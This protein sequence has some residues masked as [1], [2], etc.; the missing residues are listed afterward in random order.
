MDDLLISQKLYEHV[1]DPQ[2]FNKYLNNMYSNSISSQTVSSSGL[3]R[4]HSSSSLFGGFRS[5]SSM[6]LSNLTGSSANL[7]ALS[8]PNNNNNNNN[9]QNSTNKPNSNGYV[10]VQGN[11]EIPFSSILPGNLPESIEGLPGCSNIY[12]LEATIDRGKFHSS[13]VA[14]NTSV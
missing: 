13:L 4:S 11:Y 14:K 9:N 2:E 5:K 3:S 6:S 7:S 1:W 12:R 8:S 10:L